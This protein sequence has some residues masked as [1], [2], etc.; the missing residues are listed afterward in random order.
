[1]IVDYKKTILN[2]VSSIREY[3]NLET[4]YP[5]DKQLSEL[6]NTKKPKKVFLFLID[7]M[8]SRLLER[9]LPKDSFLRKHMINTTSTVFP[10][11]T[12]AATTAIRNGQSPN[13]T[14]WLAWTQYIKEVDDIIVPFFGSGYYTETP[15]GGRDFMESIYPTY[16]TEDE[17]TKKGIGARTIM[18]S[19][20]KDGFEDFV[21]MC[22][23]LIDC[24]YSD[25]NK[26]IYAYWDKYDT[27]MHLF[28]PDDDICDAYLTYIDKA[29][30][31]LADNLSEDTLLLVTAD[32]GQI[33]VGNTYNI[34]I[35]GYDEYLIR[36]PALEARA[37]SF[38]VKPDMLKQFEEKF[39]TDFKDEFILL[40]K[41]EVI[42]SSLFGENT[43]HPRLAEFIGDY[44]AIAKNNSVIYHSLDDHYS[45]KGQHAGSTLDE[46]MIPII[47]YM[48]DI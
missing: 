25:E 9:K 35:M 1:M 5:C 21:F 24:S 31:R 42:D 37:A 19:F 23:K 20:E 14:C 29:I 10:P 40:S 46:L 38:Y 48:K 2:Q 45:M 47:A 32:H 8:G 30:E 34:A 16:A 12:T 13:Q 36:R 43:N 15:Y 44:V 7:G 6:L 3:F 22:Q 17:L 4:Y 33:S 26:Y 18:P 28:G 41:Q 27:Y 11:T 39:K